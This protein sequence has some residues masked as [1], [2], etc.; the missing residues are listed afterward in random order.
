M[1]TSD[2][3]KLS[4]NLFKKWMGKNPDTIDQLPHSGSSRIYFRISSG[5]TNALSVYNTNSIENNAFIKFTYHFKSYNLNVP[6]IYATE[7]QNNI[8]LIEDLGN[9]NL[10]SWIYS[11]QNNTTRDSEIKNKYKLVLKELIKFQITASQNFDY[12]I[13]YPFSS[14]NKEA[15][16]FDLAYFQNQFIKARKIE[17]DE[18]LLTNDFNRFAEYLLQENSN[19]FMYR[20]FQARNIMLKNDQPFFIDYQGGRKGPLQYDVASLLYQA[21]ANLSEKTRTELLNF[22]ISEIQ[23]LVSINSKKFT[24]FYYAFT[25]VRILQTLGAYGLRGLVEGKSHFIESITPA[26]SNLALVKNKVDFLT[27]TTEL[28]RL[29]NK[30]TEKQ[31]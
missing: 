8:Y 22:Y 3:I 12:S 14:F 11:L 28:K 4:G 10:L 13:C 19:F 9:L 6:K 2:I 17:F 30:I 25:L 15:I 7:L 1:D 26:L 16:L 29:I 20:D 18:N 21:K 27:Q 31:L 23:K 24:E 5:N